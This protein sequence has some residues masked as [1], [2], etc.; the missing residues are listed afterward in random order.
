MLVRMKRHITG[1]RNGEEWPPRGGTLEVPDHE[2]A[3]LIT[4]GLAEEVTDASTSA[5]DR[6]RAATAKD[7]DR[8]PAPQGGDGEPSAPHGD[9]GL[10][11]S[12][13]DGPANAEPVEAD[14]KVDTAAPLKP[15]DR[16]R[17]GSTRKG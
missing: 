13:D 12:S 16:R 6:D 15:A 7:G 9:D 17:G 2:G 3:D 8:F 1:T 4:A 11:P 10:P 5:K 14:E